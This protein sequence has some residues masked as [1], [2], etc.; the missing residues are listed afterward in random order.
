MSEEHTYIWIIR[1]RVAVDIGQ[2]F[3]VLDV[4]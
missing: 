3:R 4:F 1:E 2:V